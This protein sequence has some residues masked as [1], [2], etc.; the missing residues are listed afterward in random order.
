MVKLIEKLLG[1]PE[2]GD[3]PRA[4]LMLPNSILYIAVGSFIIGILILISSIFDFN[5]SMVV[6]GLLVI[7]FAIGT[8]M[9]WKNS[10]IKIIDTDTFEV[11][12]LTGK[13]T[14]YRF[15]EITGYQ[16]SYNYIEIYLG[17]KRFN[18]EST[19]LMTQRLRTLLNKQFGKEVF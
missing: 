16:K 6:A 8:L 17:K 7:L 9:W 14:K 5:G 1:I 2:H 12:T 4:D 19:A 15:D 3:S 13:V 18:I 11:S 10:T